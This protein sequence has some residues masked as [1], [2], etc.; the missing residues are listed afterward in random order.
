MNDK[1]KKSITILCISLSLVFVSCSSRI[2]KH[3]SSSDPSVKQN[4]SS[5]IGI[6]FVVKT[7]ED[8]T[9]GKEESKKTLLVPEISSGANAEAVNALIKQAAENHFKK[10]IPNASYFTEQGGF[11]NYETKKSEITSFRDGIISVVFSGSFQT[12]S[13]SGI[14]DTSLSDFCHS[15][16]IDTNTAEYIDTVDIITDLDLMIECFTDGKFTLTDGGIPA[17]AES[18]VMEEYRTDYGIYPDI[19]FTPSSFCFITVDINSLSSAYAVYSI[20]LENAEFLNTSYK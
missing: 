2:T 15:V 3:E 16:I 18:G 13:D 11:Y 1:L 17:D 12:Y 19:F 8:V 10:V 6:E 5:D 20:P 7:Y 14:T 4:D 9:P